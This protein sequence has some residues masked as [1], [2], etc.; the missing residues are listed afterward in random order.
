MTPEFSRTVRVDTLG[1]SPR[2]LD[3][4][5]SAD[6][7]T[8]LAERF[9]LRA[10]H[11]LRAV[12]DLVRSG[13]S[14]TATGAVTAEVEQSCVVTGEPVEAAVDERFRIEFRP[15]ATAERAEEE[16]ELGES[17]LDV[18]FYEGAL[19]DLGE[20]VAQTLSLALDPYPRSAEAEQALREAGVKSEA[21]AGP[22]GALA[23]LR[24]RLKT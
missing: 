16:I 10:V 4:E 19:I 1:P 20:A 13:A 5:A 17:E 7:R 15:Q 12:A 14:V 6:E 22:F 23:E 18:V 21:E 8:A 9:G 2:H 11:G 24:S 3:I